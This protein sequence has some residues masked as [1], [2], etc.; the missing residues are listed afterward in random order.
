MAG[1]GGR[2][3]GR[4]VQRV[5]AGEVLGPPELAEVA[6][7]QAVDLA[8]DLV[9]ARAASGVDLL[10]D[11]MSSTI[12]TWP[13][14]MTMRIWRLEVDLERAARLRVRGT[15]RGAV[16]MAARVAASALPVRGRS[17]AFWNAVTACGVAEE[18]LPSMPGSQ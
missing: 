3:A 17:L 4:A 18:Y 1:R 13:P 10:P 8:L 2:H 7:A 14:L 5:A 16:A 6:D 11:E 12:S 9:V 15:G